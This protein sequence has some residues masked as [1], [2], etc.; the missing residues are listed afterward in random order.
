MH[1]RRFLAHAWALI[2]GTTVGWQFPAPAAANKRRTPKNRKEPY[3]LALIIDDIGY[4]QQRAN[5]FLA[6]DLPLTFSILP[7]LPNSTNLARTIQGHNHEI[8][9]HQ[10]MEP[11]NRRL[12][13]G[14]GAIYV[15]DPA[16]RIT[17]TL[18][19]NLNTNPLA[20]G[21]NNHMGSRFTANSGKIEA[22]LKVIKDQGLYFVDSVTSPRSVAHQTACNLGLSSSY[23]RFF[24]DLVVRESSI[25]NSLVRLEGSARKHGY[26]IGI[27][28]PHPATARALGRFARTHAAKE[29]RWAYVSDIIR[30]P[31]DQRP[32]SPAVE[33]R[34]PRKP[35]KAAQPALKKPQPKI[36]VHKKP[37]HNYNW[38]YKNAI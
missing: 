4:S 2:L 32:K 5:R 31:A 12:D 30:S 20:I 19:D 10:P 23:N 18:L 28:H 22:A 33:N 8:M 35:A 14:P 34:F 13:P 7:Q 16:Q 24:I 3:Q 27:G 38:F 6:L 36:P 26:A 15:K 21:V 25:Y 9:L 11:F 29:Y 1:R 17:R 37:A